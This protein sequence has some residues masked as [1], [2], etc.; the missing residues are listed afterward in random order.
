VHSKERANA[1]QLNL[2]LGEA[3]SGL[4]SPLRQTKPFMENAPANFQH[5]S[6][7]IA[8]QPEVIR[9]SCLVG[10]PLH[11]VTQSSLN[12]TRRSNFG[13]DMLLALG[14]DGLEDLA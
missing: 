4:D 14:F 10:M 2:P 3:Q 7:R 5:D 12:F 9:D 13:H 6:G 11:T 1:C 8:G